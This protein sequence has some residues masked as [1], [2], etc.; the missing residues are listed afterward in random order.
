MKTT[1]DYTIKTILEKVTIVTIDGKDI[2]IPI[3]SND[4]EPVFT[5]ETAEQKTAIRQEARVNFRTKVREYILAYMRG[6]DIEAAQVVAISPTIKSIE[7][8]TQTITV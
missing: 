7:G 4:F 8:T 3:V 5:K 6:K 2:K 1:Y